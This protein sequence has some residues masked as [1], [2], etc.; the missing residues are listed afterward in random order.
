MTLA[1]AALGLGCLSLGGFFDDMLAGL[2]G[3]LAEEEPPLYAL[4]LGPSQTE[5]PA[6][7]RGIGPT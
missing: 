4:A 1:A 3:T 6:V 2:L 7:M 5:D